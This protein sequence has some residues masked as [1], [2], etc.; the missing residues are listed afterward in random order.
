MSQTM[1]CTFSFI[2][3]QF[4]SYFRMAIMNSSSDSCM[5]KPLLQRR[6]TNL[7]QLAKKIK[8]KYYSDWDDIW[9]EG[10]NKFI[11][12]NTKLNNSF[13]VEDSIKS[14]DDSEEE[15]ELKE[16]PEIDDNI[17]TTTDDIESNGGDSNKVSA[18][19]N[20]NIK[21]ANVTK[22]EPAK[23]ITPP[24]SNNLVNHKFLKQIASAEENVKKL[25]GSPPKK[26][27]IKSKS[28]TSNLNK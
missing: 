4:F 21:Q 16:N 9:V 25:L 12:D 26:Q 3:D 11:V 1:S 27:T 24:K 19:I 2:I 5:L 6:L 8:S 28:S 20:D 23:Q 10:E 14:Q 22:G 17:Q 13:S 18:G 7:D 15:D